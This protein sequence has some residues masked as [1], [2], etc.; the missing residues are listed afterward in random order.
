MLMKREFSAGGIV[1]N[2]AGKVLLINNAAMRDP[3]KSY[4]GFPKGHLEEGETSRQAAVREVTEET[5]LEVEIIGNA[6]ESK[7]L[8]DLN[9]EKVFK[10]VTVFIMKKTGGKLKFQKGELLAVEWV[11][12]DQALD[13]LSFSQDKGL[14]KKA[15]EVYGQ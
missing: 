3:I 8:F 12:P 1:F 10:M 4:W 15:L 7:Y 14:L 11:S 9:E 2:K 6:G 5:G 13:R